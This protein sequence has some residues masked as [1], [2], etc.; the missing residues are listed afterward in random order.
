MKDDLQ[1]FCIDLTA[2][3]RKDKIVDEVI[4]FVKLSD[5]LEFSY[6]INSS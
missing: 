1:K 6:F 5:Q 3:V 2:A 4:T